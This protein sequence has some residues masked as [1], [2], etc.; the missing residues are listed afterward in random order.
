MMIWRVFLGLMLTLF[1][2]SGACADPDDGD[3]E[4]GILGTGILGT[5][6]ALGSIYVN[7]QHIEFAPDFPVDGQGGGESASLLRPGHVGAGVAEPDGADWSASYIRQIVPLIG[8]VER[9]PDGRILVLGT[10]VVMEAPDQ[11]WAHGDWVAV[12][13]LWRGD[14]VLATRIDPVE[15]GHI[16]RIEAT[17]SDPQPGQGLTLGGTRLTGLRPE[18][19]A[20]G[21]VIRAWGLATQNGLMVQELETGIFAGTPEVILA[22]GY[23]SPP[24][25][26]GRYTLLG[27][28]IVSY[29]DAP[30]MIRPELRHWL[31]QAGSQVTMQ[32]AE[33]AG[34]A[35][36][37]G[38]IETCLRA[39][40]R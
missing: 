28:G 25:P 2:V 3:R 5:I 17:I 14:Q 36:N 37:P 31:C 24:R 40:P 19:I 30:E 11:G 10:E 34:E 7:G 4:G 18:H 13:G 27:S 6:T 22:E 33:Q 20:P 23:F 39:E 21:D 35:Q 9:L 15:T 8:P 38:L 29:T 1:C 16:A 32:A 12:S 26:T